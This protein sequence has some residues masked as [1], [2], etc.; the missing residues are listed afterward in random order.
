V[1]C[2]LHEKSD[3]ISALKNQ[4]QLDRSRMDALQRE[5][6]SYKSDSRIHL[7]TI[8][9]L[10]RELSS[11]QESLFHASATID[12]LNAE[13]KKMHEQIIDAKEQVA[14]E[15]SQCAQYQSKVDYLTEGINGYKQENKEY[16]KSIL[17]LET[18]CKRLKEELTMYQQKSDVVMAVT[19]EN[20]QLRGVI[21]NLKNDVERLNEKINSQLNEN[22]T[23][24][25]HESVKERRLSE[26]LSSISEMK[27]YLNEQKAM[28]EN[29]EKRLREECSRADH[30]EA[31]LNEQRNMSESLKVQLNHER[32]VK[33]QAERRAVEIEN[34]FVEN[35]INLEKSAI[36]MI[37]A[38]IQWDQ[39]L[40]D[41]LQPPQE[42]ENEN[43]FNFQSP[44]SLKPLTKSF[45]KNIILN[46]HGLGIS[47]NPLE[48]E[49]SIDHALE[50]LRNKSD[51]LL[52]TSI[53]SVE[54][55]QIKIEQ[56]QK[57]RDVF[58]NRSKLYMKTV[59]SKMDVAQD[60]SS[61][62]SHKLVDLQTRLDNTRLELD[63][64]K[65]QRHQ[66]TS[67]LKDFQDRIL[68]EHLRKLSE[69]DQKYSST[70]A[71]L[72]SQKQMNVSLEEKLSDLV[73]R[74]E[75]LMSE[76]TQYRNFENE[77]KHI[78][79]RFNSLA[80]SNK[81][82]SYELDDRGDKLEESKRVI[83][84][85][86]SD[87][88]SLIGGVEK[89]KSQI[90]V[91]DK[92]L[93]DQ[94]LQMSTMKADIDKLKARQI[95]PE[96]QK[97]MKETQLILQ[98]S[99]SRS[100]DI[101][102]PPGLSMSLLGGA[103]TK[104]VIDFGMDKI[105]N[106][107]ADIC[108]VA[109]RL[110]IA[111]SD[112]LE[113]FEALQ[114]ESNSLDFG[115]AGGLK[116]HQKSD[117]ISIEQ[118]LFD[119]LESNSRLSVKLQQLSSEFKRSLRR[120]VD[121]SNTKRSSTNETATRTL[122]MERK[123]QNNENSY[124]ISTK[125]DTSSIENVDSRQNFLKLDTSP[126]SFLS[127]LKQADRSHSTFNQ[128]QY[129][130]GA[131]E[132]GDPLMRSHLLHNN[133]D[134]SLSRGIEHNGIS[135]LTSDISRHQRENVRFTD[136]S[137]FRESIGPR[138]NSFLTANTPINKV[139]K[140]NSFYGENVHSDVNY[141]NSSARDKNY[142]LLSHNHLTNATSIQSNYKRDPI[143]TTSTSIPMTPFTSN[144]AR[145]SADRLGKLGNDLQNLAAKLDNYSLRSSNHF[146][147]TK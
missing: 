78:T 48:M 103:S 23:L 118:D 40:E 126:S 146:N 68:G 90:E 124:N 39:I 31:A 43:L 108:K 112:A 9:E 142:T 7:S 15:S 81:L 110:V 5:L 10:K 137:P 42:M 120:S 139:D 56:I 82:I 46:R 55:V 123:F 132:G 79:E 131:H 44:R 19:R 107:L 125:Q 17:T 140:E 143:S 74:N 20:E 47:N 106:D 105:Y 59:Q 93:K 28:Y 80:E 87:K 60:K 77:M 35:K 84:K 11:K 135:H 1:S 71:A 145:D 53:V 36:L 88:S 8:E 45:Q 2:R 96:L 37:R 30:S 14:R 147:A 102:N 51:E 65:R 41:T 136:S 83:E 95:N 76:N 128:T 130:I 27:E 73:N 89:L 117:S 21:A 101:D 114:S 3:E 50:T 99:I 138:D 67:E 52:Q 113:R 97:T 122:E 91:R 12:G 61:I 70:I 129:S 49:S 63:R 92:L 94:E 104:S 13:Y 6:E 26:A 144:I 54:R 134:A 32:E 57:I 116:S 133:R 119:L 72:E 33:L 24:S 16:E 25:E 121:T 75:V 69:M 34:Q 127:H 141:K 29:Q 38:L 62:L 109:E 100:D 18:E 64:D 58:E 98:S 111:S 85:L 86:Q 115:P 4:I 22:Q 66:S